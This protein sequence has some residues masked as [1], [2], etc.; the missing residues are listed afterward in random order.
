MRINK[1][2]Y[3]VE[4]V[5]NIIHHHTLIAGLVTPGSRWTTDVRLKQKLLLIPNAT[6]VHL[7]TTQESEFLSSN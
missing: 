6:F 5:V 7:L 2:K 3:T 1:S 4:Q